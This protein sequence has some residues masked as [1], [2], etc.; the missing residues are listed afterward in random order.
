VISATFWICH[1]FKEGE[2]LQGFP[3]ASG[4]GRQAEAGNQVG[5]TPEQSAAW[6]FVHTAK[7]MQR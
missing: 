3:S 5:K 4:G 1:Y 6:L 2:I 7:P